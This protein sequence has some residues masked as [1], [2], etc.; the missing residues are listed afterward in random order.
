MTYSKDF[1]AVANKL[2]NP[3]YVVN[4]D[5]TRGRRRYF[6]AAQ[7]LLILL[8]GAV[9]GEEL[10]SVGVGLS[11]L[12]FRYAE[13]PDDERLRNKETGVL[14]GIN[15]ALKFS[16]ASW[17]IGF[18][19]SAHGGEV[20][21]DGATSAFRPHQT[22][23]D[24]LILNAMASVGYEFGSDASFTL[25]PYGAVGYRFW[26]RDILP[27]NGVRGL[28]E[29]YRWMYAAAGLE[30]G[31][32]KSERFRF[33]ADFRL[34]RPIDAKVDVRITPET[35]LELGSRTGYRVALPMLWSFGQRF[36]VAFEP[37][38][39]RQELGASAPKNGILEPSSDTNA[40][41]MNITGRVMF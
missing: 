1:P 38:Y 28:R 21:Y 24:T 18:S 40:F 23:T 19:G 31:W 2:F 20:D 27:S 8:S 14:P 32:R 33:G 36:G 10:N 3:G 11:L 12:S 41:G 25:T 16:P 30:L 17:R 26:R 22:Q 39:E 13:F 9:C 15:A 37:Y 29:D 4:C 35:T 34:I 5:R 6:V 7:S